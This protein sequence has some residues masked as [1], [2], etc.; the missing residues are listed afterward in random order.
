M[1]TIVAYV[2]AYVPT[3]NAGAETTLHDILKHLVSQGWEANVVIKPK[4][5]SFTKMAAIEELSSYEIDGVTVY[6]GVDKRTLLHHLPKADITISHLECSERTHLLSEAYGIPSIHLVHNTHPLTLR[7]MQSAS[8]LIINTEWIANYE[9]FRDFEAPSMV[10]HPPVNP[11]DYHTTRGK[12]VTLV[13]LWEDKG[14]KVFYELAKRF[15]NTPFLGV[16][17]GYGEQVI[18]DVPNV[19]IMDHTDD[20][21]KVYGETKVI[22]MPSKYESFGRVGVEAMA[23]GIPTIAHPTPGLLESLGDSGTFVDRDDLDAWETALRDLLKPAKY[24]KA[25]KLAKARS[26]ALAD[27]R[28]NNLNTLPMFLKEVVRSKT[29]KAI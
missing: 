3:H 22:L 13:N 4:L 18:E 7:W 27:A 9:G 21:K 16:K 17:G 19:T 8:G 1:P 20:M 11:D 10:I 26:E 28:A 2:H 6:P 12:S 23:S 25:S 29:G 14:S 15:P 5:V 24:G